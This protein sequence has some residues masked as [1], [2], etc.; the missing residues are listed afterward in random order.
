MLNNLF[1]KAKNLIKKS[2]TTSSGGSSSKG[3][4]VLSSIG[5]LLTGN[6]SPGSSGG[7]LSSIG[8]L[9]TGGG[10]SNAAT[11]IST[12]GSFKKAGDS[13]DS[14]LLLGAAIGGVA[15]GF[16]GHKI[17]YDSATAGKLPTSPPPPQPQPQPQPPQYQAP[18]YQEPQYPEP[19][20]TL[21]YASYRKPRYGSSSTGYS[22]M[23]YPLAL[24]SLPEDPRYQ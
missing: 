18:Q 7:V 3:G 23:S 6:K 15:G 22:P 1:N 9:L 4:G 17:G 10:L 12:I 16:I 24:P 11:L 8:G 14:S 13:F 2:P 5:G 19:E 21:H 20:E